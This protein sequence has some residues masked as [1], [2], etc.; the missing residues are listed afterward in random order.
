[1]STQIA[2]LAFTKTALDPVAADDARYR[3]ELW[4]TSDP[5]D[6]DFCS[7]VIELQLNTFSCDQGWVSEPEKGSWSWFEIAIFPDA[8]TREVKTDRYGNELRWRSHCNI[9]TID[10]DEG[11]AS[12][13]EESEDEC[14]D[15]CQADTEPSAPKP[16]THFG[17]VF[18]RRDSVL[19]DLE[20]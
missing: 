18:D 6:K 1:M 19:L 14:D 12:G 17:N 15:E 5:V 9:M 7:R 11:S 2:R 4:F 13:S 20:V 16:S 3:R 8:N 10:K